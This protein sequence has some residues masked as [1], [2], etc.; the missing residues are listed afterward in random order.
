M[1]YIRE[2]HYILTLNIPIEAALNREEVESYQERELK[3]Q[4]LKE[5]GAEME[6]TQEYIENG[7]PKV[8]TITRDSEEEKV[9]PK[10]Q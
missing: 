8:S 2:F 4:K 3:R 5:E 10:V 1:Q 7:V 9:L 6:I